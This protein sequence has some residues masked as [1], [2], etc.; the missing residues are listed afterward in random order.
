MMWH[1]FDLSG[2]IKI[3]PNITGPSQSFPF[4]RCFTITSCV[5]K[6]ASPA[7]TQKTIRQE[8]FKIYWSHEVSATGP[9]LLG[10]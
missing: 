10:L 4:L 7:L 8:Q 1:D 2:S 3:P 5:K 9:K 6:M